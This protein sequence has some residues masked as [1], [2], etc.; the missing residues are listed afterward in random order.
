M[1]NIVELYE[2]ERGNV[3]L[4]HGD[5]AYTTQRFGLGQSFVEDAQNILDGHF[6]N[7]VTENR[8]RLNLPVQHRIASYSHGTLAVFVEPP[9][10]LKEYVGTHV[11]E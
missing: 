5:R 6:S 1:A 3:A 2:D 11:D 4:I 9:T 8:H 10:S 7:M